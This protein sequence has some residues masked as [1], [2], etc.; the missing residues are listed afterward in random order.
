MDGA[1]SDLR[2]G[3][4]WQGVDIHE[5][6]RLLFIIEATTRTL[7]RLMDGNSTLKDIFRN[8]WAHLATLDPATSQMYRFSK[9][10]FV[11]YQP[12]SSHS[13]G[14]ILP[15][16]DCSRDWYKGKREH[17]P[18]ALIRDSAVS[19]FTGG[20]TQVTDPSAPKQVPQ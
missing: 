8:H 4:P 13:E 5:P 20:A 15:S 17:L 12:E 2:P 14:G 11:L 10:R 3:L 9:D 18:F 1:A 6:V 7:L 19:A 16:A